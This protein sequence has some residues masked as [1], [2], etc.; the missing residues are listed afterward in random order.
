MW[1]WGG[2]SGTAE[3][4]G[5]AHQI[6]EELDQLGAVGPDRRQS[7]VGDH[8]SALFDGRLQ[9]MYRHIKEFSGGG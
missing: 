3:L 4:D 8:G 6:L 5:I 1:I 7:V 2:G 9:V